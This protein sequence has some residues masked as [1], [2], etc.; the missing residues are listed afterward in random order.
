MESKLIHQRGLYQKSLI[1]HKIQVPFHE[2]QQNLEN[3]FLHHAK[4]KIMNQCEKEGY[5][6]EHGCKVISYSGGK[7]CDSYI[8]YDVLFEFLI[9]YPY[10]N[11]SL[12]CQIQSITKIGIKGVL[13]HDEIKNPIVVFASYLHNPSI[14]QDDNN[15]L[16]QESSKY[17]IGDIIQIRVLG[18]RFEIH[19]PNIYVL[20]KIIEKSS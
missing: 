7:S 14:F 9:C 16:N 19:D 10:E 15:L 18:H 20:G 12:E 1:R 6:A 4:K 11:M 2:L 13:T 17:K 3:M 8:Q 5:I